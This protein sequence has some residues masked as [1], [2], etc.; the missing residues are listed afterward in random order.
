MVD[1]VVNGIGPVGLEKAVE[2]VTV[3]KVDFGGADTC[4]TGG[5][6]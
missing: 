6:C 3:R 1:A 4:D 5:F 2:A